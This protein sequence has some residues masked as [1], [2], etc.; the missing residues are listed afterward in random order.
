MKIFLR[1]LALALIAAVIAVAGAVVLMVEPTAA[2]GAAK[3]LNGQQVARAKLILAQHDPRRL[4]PGDVRRLRV[5]GDDVALLITNAL[6][7]VA[8]AGA[9]VELGD[10]RLIVAASVELPASPLGRY[11]NVHARFS[12]EGAMPRL[13]GARIGELPIPG[14][15]TGPVFRAVLEYVDKRAAGVFSRNLIRAVAFSPAAVEVTYEWQPDV[16][17]AVRGE[18][19]NPALT[20]E[21][22]ALSR[23]LREGPPLQGTGGRVTLA[24]LLS[25]LGEAVAARDGD[26]VLENRALIIVSEAF[27]SGRDLGL[28][29]PEL[30]KLALPGARVSLRGR[31][32]F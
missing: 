24:A 31:R 32:D 12:E 4:K 20:A 1:C 19:M 5:T 22:V 26:P 25:R 16:L 18:L 11:V 28:L 2:V 27:V 13:D 10:R 14:M 3:E 9:D 6:A 17:E 23:T 21:I 30:A 29:A 15:L 7:R 8:A